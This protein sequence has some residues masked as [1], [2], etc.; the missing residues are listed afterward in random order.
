MTR[1]DAV[2]I[3]L[4][5]DD[6]Q[7]IRMAFLM[8]HYRSHCEIG[9]KKIAEARKVLRRLAMACTPGF[10][11]VPLEVLETLCDDLNTPGVIAL[12]H[13]YKASGEGGKLFAALR[14]LGFFGNT[15]LPDELKAFPADH[16]WRREMI[17][18]SAVGPDQ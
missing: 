5:V 7:A 8:S 4:T 3:D 17:G 12:L 18:P 13:R 6:G 9:P 10:D 1:G 15:C 14:F 16:V 11:P 2:V